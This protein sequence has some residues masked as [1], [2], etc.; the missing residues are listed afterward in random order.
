MKK[1]LS[2]ILA[3]VLS[4]GF[5]TTQVRGQTAGT[6][7]LEV[8]IA[9]YS[10]NGPDHWTVAWVTTANGTFIKTLRKQGTSY[11]WTSSQWQQHCTTWNTARG[12]TTGSQ[13]VDGYTSA[14]ATTYT[15]TNNPIILTWN[16]RDTNNVVMPDGDY[17]FWVQY[18]EENTAQGPWTTNGITWTKGSS[19]STNTYPN[20]GANFTNIKVTWTPTITAVAPTITT[21]APTGSATVGVPYTY[22]CAASGTAPI[23]FTAPGLPTGL[24]MSTAGVI[25]GTPNAAG[26]FSG[27][28]TAANGTAPNATQAFSIN[29]SVVPAGISGIELQGNKLIMS[30]TGPAN[31]AYTVMSST[32]A[33][34]VGATWTPSGNGTFNASGLF[35]FTNAISAGESQKFYK[36]RIP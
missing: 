10:V 13:V 23:T 33:A 29:V 3:A 8:G 19:S 32:D 1:I 14:T 24:S 15:G 12:G 16:C 9:S 34:P 30:G 27:T 5:A 7:K 31:G 25:S 18:S 21:A 36:L 6:A 17:I 11:G 4:V 28:I 26:T 20:K 22:T 2:V 35:R